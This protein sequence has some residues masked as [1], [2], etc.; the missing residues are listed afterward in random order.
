MPRSTAHMGLDSDYSEADSCSEPL[1]T[2][3][4]DIEEVLHN[5]G[6]HLDPHRIDVG[7]HLPI[8]GPDGGLVLYRFHGEGD[9]RPLLDGRL[10]LYH[11]N[12]GGYD[13]ILLLQGRVYQRSRWYPL[14]LPFH[15][16][17]RMGFLRAKGRCWK[18]L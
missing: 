9:I 14:R 12:R 3:C 18:G 16:D 8:V 11:Q 2:P 10:C 6:H 7:D 17:D 13:L 1:D 4:P 15:L 5:W